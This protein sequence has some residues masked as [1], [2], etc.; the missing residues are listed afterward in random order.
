M[1]DM[2]LQDVR[3]IGIQTHSS[4][5]DVFAASRMVRFQSVTFMAIHSDLHGSTGVTLSWCAR[6][7]YII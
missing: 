1:G 7:I 5:T 6:G 2:R 4:S 3:Q